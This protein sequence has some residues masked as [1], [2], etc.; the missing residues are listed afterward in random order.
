MTFEEQLELAYAE[1]HCAFSYEKALQVFCYYFYTFEQYSRRKHPRLSTAKLT[2]LLD[3]IDGDGLFTAEDY[4]VMIEA[5]FNTKFNCDR[6]ICH[7][8]SGQIRELRFY[9]KCY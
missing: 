9:E 6:N 5:Y 7:F 3:R 2:E 4:P 1:S 8:F